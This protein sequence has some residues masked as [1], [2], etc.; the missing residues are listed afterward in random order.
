MTDAFQELIEKYAGMGYPGP[1]SRVCTLYPGEGGAGIVFL[2]PK[3]HHQT[4]INVL[5]MVGVPPEQK[6]PRR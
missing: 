6:A 2:G 5:Q 1:L 4:T 3:E